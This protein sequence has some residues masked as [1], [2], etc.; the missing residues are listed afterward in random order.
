MFDRQSKTFHR[1]PYAFPVSIPKT[2]GRV[3]FR[4]QQATFDLEPGEAMNF[5]N[6]LVDAAEEISRREAQ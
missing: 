6:S 3:R 4:I 1:R 5:S 2:G